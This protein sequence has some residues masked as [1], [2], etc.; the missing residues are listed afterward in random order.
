M[1]LRM[2]HLPRISQLKL[3]GPHKP[4]HNPQVLLCPTAFAVTEVRFAM[5]L[6]RSLLL[7]VVLSPCSIPT[8]AQRDAKTAAVTFTTIDV[9][10]AIYT[11]I[12][13]INSAGTMVGSYGQN[14]LTDGHGFIYNN[15]TFTYFDYPGE[16]FTVPNGINDSDLIVGSAGQNPVVVGFLYDGAQFTEIVDANDTATY[17][18]G[19]NN[20]GLVVGG[21]G[22]IYTTKG[23]EMRN[24]HFKTL[25]VPGQYVYVRASGINNLGTIVGWTDSDGFMCRANT[26]SIV[27]YPGATY[28]KLLGVN[29]AGIMVGSYLS[30]NC[31]C[32]FASKNG[33]SISFG[34][35]G[36]ALTAA[37]G[38][39]KSGQIVGE[40]TFDYST[41]HGFV[42]NPITDADFR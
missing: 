6:H 9:P 41:W 20:A 10:G 7:L 16:N 32:G 24:G 13:G 19:I 34:Y 11:E 42:T 3:D 17:P 36:A 2:A 27:D 22:S 12:L 18:N 28:T 26:C 31:Y 21:A 4:E 5:K 23:F 8:L 1:F 39:N 37:T 14:T 29:D 30:S 38:I 25:N 40:Y 35:P 15:S 33:K